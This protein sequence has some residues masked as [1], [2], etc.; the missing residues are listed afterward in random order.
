MLYPI[1]TISYINNSNMNKGIFK[2]TQQYKYN[3]YFN[4]IIN[5]FNWFL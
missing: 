3:S 1:L 2:A 5:I 4:A